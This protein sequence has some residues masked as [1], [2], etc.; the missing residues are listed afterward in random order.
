[1]DNKQEF[2]P[3]LEC[4]DIITLV[5]G[6]ARLVQH[7]EVTQGYIFSHPVSLN[8]GGQEKTQPQEYNQSQ[9]GLFSGLKKRFN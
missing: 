2:Q 6:V 9:S 7:T 8:Q 5:A 4:G 1:M 3:Y